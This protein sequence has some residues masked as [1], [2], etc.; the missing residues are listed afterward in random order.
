VDHDADAA[1]IAPADETM[2]PLVDADEFIKVED[3][4]GLAAQ[5]GRRSVKRTSRSSGYVLPCDLR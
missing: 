3:G 2:R 5:G 4:K 1:D